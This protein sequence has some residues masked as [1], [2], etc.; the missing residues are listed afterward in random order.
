M[1]LGFGE[2]ATSCGDPSNTLSGTESP[3]WGMGCGGRGGTN[4]PTLSPLSHLPALYHPPA[5]HYTRPR[6]SGRSSPSSPGLAFKLMM[7]SN[8]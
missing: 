4:S 7:C 1:G 3:G 5:T 6:S 2:T 8:I